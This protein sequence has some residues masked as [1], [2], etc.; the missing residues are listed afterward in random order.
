MTF[1]SPPTKLYDFHLHDGPAKSI[2]I[3]CMYPGSGENPY[4]HT[5]TTFRLQNPKPKIFFAW[6]N[7]HTLPFV[8][9][10]ETTDDT[11]PF[12][13][14]KSI[15]PISQRLTKTTIRLVMATCSLYIGSRTVKAGGSMMGF[16]CADMK[17]CSHI[18]ECAGCP[19]SRQKKNNKKCRNRQHKTT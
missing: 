19:S 11:L 5:R 9:S 12:P 16:D 1:A 3:S 15:S 4:R 18:T 6:I 14:K 8:T 17:L 13:S 7:T 2:R 10:V